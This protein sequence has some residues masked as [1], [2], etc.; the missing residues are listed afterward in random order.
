LELIGSFGVL[1]LME[2]WDI[3]INREFW[4][5]GIDGVLGCWN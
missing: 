5:V 4:D 1:E 2:F 3:G